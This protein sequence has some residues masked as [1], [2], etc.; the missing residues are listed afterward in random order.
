MGY[1]RGE[2]LVADVYVLHSRPYRDTSA[3]VTSFSEDYGRID[4]VAKGIRAKKNAKIALLQPF[5][6]L[7]IEVY[8]NNELKNLVKVEAKGIT[9]SL[10]D[11]HLYSAL[12]A[13]ELL[14]RLLPVELSYPAIYER[15]RDILSAF[16]QQ[17]PI[18]P[19]LRDFE[20]LLLDEF[21][22]GVEFH[23][24]AHSGLPVEADQYYTYDPE[25]GVVLCE[26]VYQ[27]AISGKIL[28]DIAQRVWN[29][30]SLKVAKYINR[31][32]MK[33][34]LGTKPLKSRDLFNKRP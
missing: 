25:Q 34:L 31:I 16:Y 20:C 10:Q 24:D 12:Y 32:A 22:Y 13:N 23:Y 26:P 7:C 1:Y 18:E 30:D 3:I 33:V 21:G 9:I 11:K 28:L 5:T 4:F 6:P 29:E 14:V 19:T 8:G 2:R 15:Y 27:N 17:H